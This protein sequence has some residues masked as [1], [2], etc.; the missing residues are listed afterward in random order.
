M[1]LRAVA[2]AAKLAV[3]VQDVLIPAVSARLREIGD[4]M[5]AAPSNSGGDIQ[6]ALVM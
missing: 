5:H 6:T 2:E 4:L 3:N 1:T